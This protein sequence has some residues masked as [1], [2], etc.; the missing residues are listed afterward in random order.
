M[1][2]AQQFYLWDYDSTLFPLT[3][4]RLLVEKFSSE[5]RDFALS[6]V[7]GNDLGFQSQH[8]VFASKRGWFLRPT[9]KLDPVAEFFLYDFVYRNRALFRKSPLPQ[10]KTHGFRIVNGEPISLLGS[11]TGF[12]KHTAAFRDG[13]KAYAY[14]D[15]AA[16]FNHVYQHD[17]VRWFEDAGAS[18]E[19][20]PIFGRFLRET[21]SGRSIDCL[22]QGLYP[23]KMIGSAFLSFLE[24]STRIRAAMT[25][26]LMDDMWL[27][28][29]DQ[30]TLI[31]DFL[32]VQGLLSDRGLAMNDQKSAILEGLM[33][34]PNCRMIWMR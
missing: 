15:V 12:K 5:L 4:N 18:S 27:F 34:R 16:Y 14:F 9:V 25:V 32:M 21:A 20:V 28:D 19:E 29:D 2:N 11:Y 30:K 7:L 8:R 3:T 23:A 22:P 31:G 17:L 1:V 13:F 6:E 10:R 26:R 24:N 33:P